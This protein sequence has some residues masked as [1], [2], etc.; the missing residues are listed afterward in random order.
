ML[1]CAFYF[2]LT[3][4]VW[5]VSFAC[6]LLCLVCVLHWPCTRPILLH[7]HQLSS[8]PFS[9]AFLNL[10]CAPFCLLSSCFILI[11]FVWLRSFFVV[12]FPSLFCRRICCC[13]SIFAATFVVFFVCTT[14]T[15]WKR[16]SRPSTTIADLLWPFLYT[17]YPN[18]YFGKFPGHSGREIMCSC[19]CVS[20]RVCFS[21]SPRPIHL[22]SPMR[23][24]THPPTTITNHSYSSPEHISCLCSFFDI[25]IGSI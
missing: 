6:L 1:F 3:Q 11:L 23:T 24:H 22:Y 8:P 15:Y 20:F 13:G 4:I 18:M 16:Y 12:V 14:W 17:P 10:F 25:S 21:L 5:L 7:M 19:P 2:C 9:I